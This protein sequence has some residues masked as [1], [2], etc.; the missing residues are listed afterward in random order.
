MVRLEINYC[1]SL[2]ESVQLTV[3]KPL[4]KESTMRQTSLLGIIYIVIGFVVA[5][6]YGYLVD[7][8]TISNILSALVAILLWP[9]LLLGANLH[10]SF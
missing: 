1:R 5:S 4:I 3:R 8:N 9:V 7:L 2:P 6:K 10:L